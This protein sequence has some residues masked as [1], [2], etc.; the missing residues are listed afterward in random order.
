MLGLVQTASENQRVLA[1]FR[2]DLGERG[3]PLDQPL[4]AVFDGAQGLRA[5]VREVFGE[6]PVQRCQWRKREDVVSYLAKHAQYFHDVTSAP[7][8]ADSVM[9]FDIIRT[10]SA[11][12][13]GCQPCPFI[14]RP[15]WKTASDLGDEVDARKSFMRY[16]AR[17]R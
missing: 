2:R 7:F 14:G 8:G 3:F 9:R 4:L 11:L 10:I 13:I 6:I 12:L 17:L 16:T 5:A 15:Y 1:S